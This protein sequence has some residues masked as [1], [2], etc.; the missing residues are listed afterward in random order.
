MY[1]L[2]REHR[3]VRE[4]AAHHLRVVLVPA[5]VDALRR[6]PAELVRLRRVHRHA[7]RRPR[8]RVVLGRRRHRH[9]RGDRGHRHQRRRRRHAQ[10]HARHRR[11]RSKPAAW[12]AVLG[13]SSSRLSLSVTRRRL[14]PCVACNT[15]GGSG[16][17]GAGRHLLRLARAARE[18]VRRGALRGLAGG[19]LGRAAARCGGEHALCRGGPRSRCGARCHSRVR[20]RRGRAW[21]TRAR[22]RGR[23]RAWPLRGAVRCLR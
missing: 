13:A 5:P 12:R 10:L 22:A 2:P 19:E 23:T 18:R 9:A 21:G 17:P 7:P 6:K 15:A 16:S 14:L 8:P 3:A 20:R 11:G 4:L 1:F